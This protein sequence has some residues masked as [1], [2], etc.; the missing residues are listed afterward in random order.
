M[1]NMLSGGSLSRLSI[2][3]LSIVPYITASIIIQLM[4]PTLPYLKSLRTEGYSGQ[5]KI[6]QYTKYLT[7]LVAFFQ[8]FAVVKT[9]ES[10]GLFLDISIPFISQSFIISI[11]LVAGV[12]LLLWIGKQI[13][14]FG[15][16]NGISLII[17]TGIVAEFPR[18]M[19][20]FFELIKNGALNPFVFAIIFIT[21]I[22]TIS[23]II[24]I[25]RSYRHIPI[26][27]SRVSTATGIFGTPSQK[28]ASIPLK[29]NT[30][31][32]IPPIFASSVLLLP[33][34]V[35]S[36]L[37]SSQN[38]ILQWLAVN[39]SHGKPVFIALYIFMIV[40]FTYFYTGIAFDANEV[41]QNLKKGGA[42]IQGVRP[43]ESTKQYLITLLAKLSG[44]AAIYLSIICIIPEIFSSYTSLAMA[45]GGTSLLIVVNV[46]TDT[47][48]Q[49][50][51]AMLPRKY[52]KIIENFK[53]KT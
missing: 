45:L 11:S 49:V 9:I 8:S 3:T 4:V 37:Q 29:I 24:L 14:S 5:V 47:I 28:Q 33:L 26:V 12:V 15:I 40:F 7:I 42:L 50:K 22:L 19:L 52:D 31:G 10:A 51:L 16:G 25:E 27:S 18:T 43:G 6:Y 34:T 21:F 53:S 36:L 13:T 2:F 30:A 48:A 17:F 44:I 23:L 39:L 46:S 20:S 38:P 1:F 35:S 32:V 41:S